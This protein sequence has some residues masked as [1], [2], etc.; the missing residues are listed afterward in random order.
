MGFRH[1]GGRMK[2]KEEIISRV[3]SRKKLI[4]A[5]L[6][7]QQDELERI[8]GNFLEYYAEGTQGKS[9]V[10]KIENKLEAIS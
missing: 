8:I 2:T 9:D 4:K 5:N 6:R 10:N 1:R 7:Y 3:V